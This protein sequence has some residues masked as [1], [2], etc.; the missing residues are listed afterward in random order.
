[1]A[2]REPTGRTR[3]IG[4]ILHERR[5]AGSR[6]PPPGI[7]V[8]ARDPLRLPARR[9]TVKRRALLAFAALAGLAA[10]PA[11]LVSPSLA[12][13][14]ARGSDAA[15]GSPADARALSE[16]ADSTVAEHVRIERLPVF[17]ETTSTVL[18]ELTRIANHL[19][20]RTRESVVRRE[21]LV[22]EGGPS[23]SLRLQ[24]SERLLRRRG[25]FEWASVRA[26][27]TDSGRTVVVR[28]QDLW[29]LGL[30]ASFEKKAGLTEW[31]FGVREK[32]LLG[33]GHAL[34]W[35]QVVSSD[36]PGALIGADL[37]RPFRTRAVATIV[38]Y[39]FQDADQASA[40]VTRPVETVFDHIGWGT[41]GIAARGQQRFFDRGTE[42]GNSPYR[43]EEWGGYI[44][45]YPGGASKVAIGAGWVD[46]RMRPRG[47]PEAIEPGYAPPPRFEDHRFRGPLVFLG[48]MKRRFVQGENLLRYGNVED[49]PVGWSG[50]VAFGPNL[51]GIDEPDRAFAIRT[52]FAA[53]AYPWHKIGLSVEATGSLFVQ[54]DR[55]LGPRNVVGLASI[56]WQ[57]FA[58]SLTILQLLGNVGREREPTMVHYLGT[59]TGLRGFPVREFEVRD[60]LLLT[61]E[62]RIWSGWE[63]LWTGIG[64]NAFVDAALP[65]RDGSIDT[66]RARAGA[67][68]GLLLGSRKASSPP[69]RIEVAWRTDEPAPPT[70]SVM[71]STVLRILPQ[72]EFPDPSLE[73]GRSP[74]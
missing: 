36:Q 34:R 1:M 56:G 35:T 74:R 4:A 17:P 62:E 58:R 38:Y 7:A 50:Q 53:G 13:A 61:L 15:D 21:I 6:P 51:E 20:T 41:F 63:V 59:E 10:L 24:E 37:W 65:S 26:V 29:T 71:T 60:Y 43:S 44:G 27:P 64:A 23:D 48:W 12:R 3:A 16:T 72:V 69:V 9:V 2:L 30:D 66:E 49:V 68:F 19:H 18:G 11:P 70:F 54:S 73:F 67:G 45:R 46:R 55:S 8:R 47:S 25:I 28:T 40:Y 5:F 22:H 52:R 32:N 39:D 14:A 42:I 57:P 31:T 33:S